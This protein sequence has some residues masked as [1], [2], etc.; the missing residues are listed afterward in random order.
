[1]SPAGRDA[2]RAM[3]TRLKN[4]LS[5]L[6][7]AKPDEARAALQAKY[8]LAGDYLVEVRRL[9][10]RGVEEGWLCSMERGG[11]RFSRLSPPDKHFPYSVDAVLLSGTGA[12]HR[13][14]KGEVNVGWPT[15]G[16][17]RFCGVEPGWSV[18]APGSRHVPEVTG[19]GMLLLYFLPGGA[20]EWG[21]A[22]S[23]RPAGR[24]R[25]VVEKA[26]RTTAA[27]QA[28]TRKAAA[29]KVVA[30]KAAARPQRAEQAAAAGAPGAPKASTRPPKASAAPS[31]RSAS[32]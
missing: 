7:L 31:R 22:S 6:D 13:H 19:G 12:E 21:S 26:A 5:G 1:M 3:L 28:V 24:A 18:F 32:R 29:P 15:D 2:L 8:P 4:D 11:V 25:A 23:S 14:P 9:C 10:E 16:E 20:I 30:K 17:P 27:K